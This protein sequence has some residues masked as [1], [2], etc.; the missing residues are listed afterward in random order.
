MFSRGLKQE[1]RWLALVIGASLFVGWSFKAPATCL[2]LGLLGFVIWLL[3]RIAALEKWVDLVRKNSSAPD[4]FSGVWGKIADDIR[5]ICKRYEKDKGRLQA[6]VSRVQEMTAALSDAVILVDRHANIEWWNHSAQ[7][8]LNLQDIDHRHKLV[9]IIR[10]PRF[11][12]YFEA[13]DYEQPFDIE[14]LRREGQHLEFHI[15]PFGQGERLVIVRDATRVRRLEQ[16]RKDFVSNVSH[17]LRTPLT[18]IKGYIETLLDAPDVPPKW[19]KALVQMDSQSARMGSL[20]NDLIT[21]SRLETDGAE[22]QHQQVALASLI[23]MIINDAKALSQDRH[24][25]SFLGPVDLAIEGDEKE[26]HSAISNLVFNAVKYSPNGG[27][28]KIEINQTRDACIVSV[29]D[30]GLGIDHK[31]I[32]RITERFYRADEGRSTAMG[33]TGLG[34][35]IAKHVLMRHDAELKITSRLG[36]GSTFA[37]HFP[38]SRVVTLAPKE[39]LLMPSQDGATR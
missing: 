3:S 33:G 38:K 13:R 34:L 36:N 4:D 29:S 24:E 37:C 31:H 28:I 27:R 7:Q 10:N 11:V 6:V 8:V 9:N 2:V 23:Q 5:R 35:A 32:P 21:L 26:L 18:V 1:L 14:S 22:E 17:E 20:V 19:E 30:Q 39:T 16:V 12:A 25:F 15:H